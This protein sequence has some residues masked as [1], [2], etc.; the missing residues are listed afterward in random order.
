MKIIHE[1]TRT[2]VDMTGK[3]KLDGCAPG[4]GISVVVGGRVFA[5][6]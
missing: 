3:W 5:R 6:W 1:A 2:V 4:I